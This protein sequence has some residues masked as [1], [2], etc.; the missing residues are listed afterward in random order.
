MAIK[1]NLKQHMKNIFIVLII[2][3]IFPLF[4]TGQIKNKGIPYILNYSRDD[5]KAATQ[6]WAAIQDK[7]E[8]MYFGNTRGVLEFDGQNWKLIP[9]TNNLSAR[10]LAKDKKGRIFV[11]SRGEFGY[12]KADSI[13][14]LSYVSLTE[15]IDIDN[16]NFKNISPI[17]I[18]NDAVY[19]VSQEIIFKY[20]NHKIEVI[21]KK[22][23]QQAYAIDNRIFIK[24]KNKGIS[25]LVDGEFKL[26]SGGEIL[27]KSSIR[28]VLP[29]QDKYL[30]VTLSDGLF[31]FDDTKFEKLVTPID[32]FLEGKKIIT[33][34]QLK[35]GEYAFGMFTAGLLLTN[36]ELK[37]IQHINSNA[38]LQNNQVNSIY[39]DSRSNVWLGL[40]N[41][42][43]EVLTSLPVS[44]FNENYGLDGTVYSS[45]I[46]KEHLYIGTS[47]GAYSIKWPNFENHFDKTNHFQIV[48]DPVQVFS[49]DTS[50]NKVLIAHGL[51]ISTADISKHSNLKLDK[52]IVYRFLML[53]GNQKFAIAG[54]KKGLLLL[55]FKSE[56]QKRRRKK[57]KV[58]GE[59]VFKQHIKGFNE[60]C[61]HIQIDNDNH[62]WFSSKTKG[63]ARLSL[64]NDFTSVTTEWY[65]EGKGIPE[66][67]DS[68]IFN[69]TNNI[70]V[71][72]EGGLYRYNHATNAFESD[73]IFNDILSKDVKIDLLIEDKQGNIWFKQKRKE[74]N[75]NAS[76][77][78]MGELIRQEDGSYYLN[79]TP[80]YKLRNNVY[81]IS[82]VSSNEIIIG[83]EKG[84]IHYDTRIQK[85]HYR[86]YY[87]LLREVRFVSNDSIIFDGTNIDS[88][89]IASLFQQENQLR[90][91]P[92]K[93]NDIRFS[94]SAP[95]YDEPEKIKFKFFLEGNDHSW[96]D[97]R[98]ENYK[99]YSNLREGEY[100][101]HVIAKNI[102]EIE[103]V[104]ATYKF[105]IS[106]PWFRTIW[107]Y[108]LYIVALALSIWG[109]V[110]L[111]VRRLR[112][113]KEHLEMV[114][115]ERTAE[116]NQA[117]E[118][119]EATNEMLQ[120]SNE[121][122]NAKNKSITA[123]ITYAKRIQDAMLPLKD[124]IKQSLDRYFILFKPRDIVS[125]D[126]YWFAEK[127]NKIIIAAV[128]STGHGVP[129]AFMSMIGSEILT[130]IV[131]QGIT[132]PSIILDMK[133]KYVQKALKQNLTDNQDGM[134]MTL[135]T[136][137]KE[138]KIVEFAGAKNPL[139]YIQN[140]E[141]FQIK[142]DRQSIGGRK[143][144]KDKPFVNHVISYAEHETHFYTFSDG[145]QD[146]F[147]G[148][149]NRKFMVKRMKDLIIQHYTKSM[150]EQEKILNYTIE[151]WM[152]D[153][154]QTDDIV[155]IGFVLKP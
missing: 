78:E 152:K 56:K 37:P 118:E 151:S 139:I 148:P 102:Y 92:F 96:S 57:K 33:S 95:F 73:T 17:L 127:N 110:R 5:Y 3:L 123:S 9:L 61:R 54:T 2:L 26:I 42:I 149:S 125:G 114:V 29:Y 12:L 70:I 122:I 1:N 64:N 35:N 21:K 99:E 30:F 113:Q 89:G 50:N 41:G 65:N 51:G 15:L 97:W 115:K 116:I 134:D 23:L 16:R 101:F 137:D 121:Q 69:V 88:L 84:F 128:D 107:A 111:S 150:N 48:G 103:S 91:V 87:A 22:G 32:K 130:T 106:P 81:S 79:K 43:S 140:G 142:G 72:T 135:C 8:V 100:T 154:Q 47:R 138:K 105:T 53:H 11:G 80:F 71:G 49:I 59:W 98:E 136:I 74:K 24:E 120:E 10:S 58:K 76:I 131:N 46:F 94:F 4:A 34:I 25:E 124:K 90:I 83:G 6:N 129:G 14:H 39:Q 132:Q 93:L 119:I 66:I 85:D 77:Y 27:K 75:T 104:E 60:S 153:V 117:K 126:F 13:G 62:I 68:R 7:R 82:P 40:A 19:F 45:K 146:Q 144:A 38:G 28:A 55:E 112:K 155:V 108:I 86:P 44:I 141:L 143:T 20:A 31:L 147:G 36:K 63:I 52:A 145:F 133:N 67:S 109:I 18:V